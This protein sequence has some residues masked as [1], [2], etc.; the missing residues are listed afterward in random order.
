MKSSRFDTHAG[1]VSNRARSAED[2][3]GQRHGEGK[4]R[5]VT[6]EEA[7]TERCAEHHIE[8]R[9]MSWCQHSPSAREDRLLVNL[10]F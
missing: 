7:E 10:G 2:V 6:L 3:E 9:G 1:V 4:G 5:I 8:V